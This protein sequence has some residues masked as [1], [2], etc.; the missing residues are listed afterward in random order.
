MDRSRLWNWWLWACTQG[1]KER[2]MKERMIE[3]EE[4]RENEQG[5]TGTERERERE[6]LVE[7]LLE[8]KKASERGRSREG[9]RSRKWS[10]YMYTQGALASKHIVCTPLSFANR[11]FILFTTS[12]SSVTIVSFLIAQ[13][14]ERELEKHLSSFCWKNKR[15]WYHYTN[16]DCELWR[17]GVVLHA[18]IYEIVGY[19]C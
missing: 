8:A 2:K 6:R 15:N 18:L 3:R 19:S 16:G 1:A 7:G 17:I 10:T 12:C 5:K 14:I 11:R 4:E 13:R 9:P